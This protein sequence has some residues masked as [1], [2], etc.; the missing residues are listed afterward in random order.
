M[1]A[2]ARQ[3]MRFAGK[4]PGVDRLLWHG[5][6]FLEGAGADYLSPG[7]QARHVFRQF[8]NSHGERIALVEGLRDRVKPGWRAMLAPPGEPVI[9]GGPAVT[10]RLASWQEK[11]AHVAGFLDCH[12]MSVAGRDVLEIGAYDGVT[13]CVLAQA[14]AASVTGIDIAAYYI[15]QTADETLDQQSIARKNAELEQLRAVFRN[16]A[17][18]GAGDRVRFL[19]DDICTS[20]V[21]DASLDMI[22]SWEVMEHVA[23]PA[24]AFAQMYRMLRPGGVVFHEYNP[25]FSI[26]GG[27]SLCTLDFLWGHARLSD[28]DFSRYLEE[29]RPREKQLALSFFRNNLNRMTLADLHVCIRRAGF[30]ELV[31]IPWSRRNHLDLLDAGIL[32]QCVRLYPSAT[33]VDL[34]SPAVWV[35]L[36]K[37]LQ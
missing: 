25:F 20:A 17:G 34:V 12:G 27:H 31:V 2:L 9:P 14:G 13:A 11:F 33:P 37:P 3:A 1:K 26:D 28:A 21:D 35:L 19:E 36:R 4:L 29:N 22:F 23:D 7:W 15:N 10:R 32:A 16:A 18:A 8:T 6:Q 24:T 5:S 30:D